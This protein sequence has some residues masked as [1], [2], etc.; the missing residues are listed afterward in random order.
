MALHGGSGPTSSC[1]SFFGRSPAAGLMVISFL[2]L[3][4][5][6][7]LKQTHG[8]KFTPQQHIKVH[9]QNPCVVNQNSLCPF[10]VVPFFTQVTDELNIFAFVCSHGVH[11][12]VRVGVVWIH[13]GV[14]L[15]PGIDGSA[16]FQIELKQMS[17]V[18]TSFHFTKTLESKLQQCVSLTK[19]LW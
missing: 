1:F 2:L 18:R 3:C 6:Y 7:S 9:H 17:L 15:R 11:L 4:S 16:T 19:S 14:T 10:F 12:L 8:A 5:L 13:I